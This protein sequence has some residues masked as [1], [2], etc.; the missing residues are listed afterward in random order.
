MIGL[1]A[2]PYTLSAQE[3]NCEVSVNDRQISGSSYDYISE[4]GPALERYINEHRW[5]NDRYDSHERI[6]CRIQIVLTD[7]DSQ[8]NYEAEALISLRRPVYNTMQETASIIL[9]D[10]NWAFSYPRGRSLIHD[11][12]QF[13]NLTSFIDL[14]VYVMLG[15]DY[16]SFSEL[17]GSRHFARALD[18][19]E[20]GQAANAPGWGR[21]IGSQRN[22]YGLISDLN[23]PG[24]EDLRRSYYQYHRL[25]LDQFTVD[26]ENARLEIMGAIDRIRENKRRASRN[27]LFDIFFDTKYSEIVSVFQDAASQKRLEAYNLLRDADP[28]H[29]SA[30]ERLRE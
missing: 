26:Q 16:D 25:G 23:N 17:G 9:S 7:V 4:L 29:S 6:R 24:Y 22:R 12:L 14:Y 21:S 5:T 10:N 18:I 8:F 19:L 3:F 1:A 13:D 11:D 30:Y 2:I 15:F 27:Y 28:G 20:M